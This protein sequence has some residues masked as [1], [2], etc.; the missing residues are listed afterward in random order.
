LGLDANP[1]E[2]EPGDEQVLAGEDARRPAALLAPGRAAARRGDA[3]RERRRAQ[4]DEHPLPDHHAGPLATREPNP[5][6]DDVRRRLSDA[7]AA[8]R[9]EPDRHR[10]RAE[11]GDPGATRAHRAQDTGDTGRA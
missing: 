8:R 3:S 2:A 11:D 6:R 10:E 9:D 5:A 4:D 1:L 7:P